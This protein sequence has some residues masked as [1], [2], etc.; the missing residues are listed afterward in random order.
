LAW[1]DKLFVNNTLDIKE[2]HMHALDFL[3]T[4]LT[5]SGLSEFGLFHALSQAHTRKS[6]S[7]QQ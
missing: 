4:W 2:N 1:Q 5:F 6:S 7:R 3:S